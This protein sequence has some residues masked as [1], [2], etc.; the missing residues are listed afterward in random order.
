[1]ATLQKEREEEEE[2]KEKVKEKEK[3]ISELEAEAEKLVDTI[4]KQTEKIK[5]KVIIKKQSKVKSTQVVQ[6][7]LIKEKVIKKEI[8]E[9]E[10]IKGLIQTY[11]WAYKEN[12]FPWM[13]FIPEKKK[14]KDSWQEEVESWANEWANFLFDWSKEFLQHIVD[15]FDLN[16]KRP[17]NALE[18]R[19]ESLQIIMEHLAK[20]SKLAKW[21]NDEKTRLRVYWQSLEKWGEF[22]YDWAFLVGEERLTLLD[23]RELGAD[24]AR[25]FETLPARDL[26]EI[27]NILVK[28]KKA[29][30]IDKKSFKLN[31]E[32]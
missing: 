12:L 16:T 13:Y 14:D 32:I 20:D 23:L 25:G 28:N 18:D 10:I 30:W 9:E 4:T 19:E 2:I 15:K 27:V 11:K 26:R 31:F 1:M 24:I 29:S 5:E 7:P 6:K 17:F 22:L 21:L 8:T 3:D